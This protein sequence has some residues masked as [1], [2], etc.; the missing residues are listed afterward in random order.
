M[1][2]IFFNTLLILQSVNLHRSYHCSPPVTWDTT[3][4]KSAQNW[5]DNLASTNGFFHSNSNYGEN[6]AMVFD[7]SLNSDA[8]PNAYTSIGLWYAE[9]KDYQYNNPGFFMNTGHF[10]QL[11]WKS[12][13]RIGVGISKNSFSRVIVVMQFDPPGNYDT[14]TLFKKNVKPLCT[15]LSPPPSPLPPPSPPAPIQD[16]SLYITFQNNDT[17]GYTTVKAIYTLQALETLALPYVPHVRFVNNTGTKAKME[18][19]INYMVGP[20]QNMAIATQYANALI[21]TN[22]LRVAGMNILRIFYRFG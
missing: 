15:A 11:V 7:P 14:P 12:S 13:R 19:E 6:L 8:T 5:A 20:F 2:S 9:I 17:S 18:Y 3:I 4:Q 16:I 21:P 1:S 10:T 22:F